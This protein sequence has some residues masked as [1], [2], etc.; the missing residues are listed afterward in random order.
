MLCNGYCDVFYILEVIVTSPPDA[1]ECITESIVIDE[2]GKEFCSNK[3]GVIVIIPEGSIKSGVNAELKF[4]AMLSAPVK[5]AKNTKPVS[6]I[7]WLC[8]NADLQK[9]I[10]IKIPH[11]VS[12][13]SNADANYLQFAKAIHSSSDGSMMEIMDGG[14]FDVGKSHGTIEVNH[15]CYYCILYNYYRNHNLVYKYQAVSFQSKQP[16]RG[17]WK[18]DICIVP[19]LPTCLQVS[20]YISFVFYVTSKYVIE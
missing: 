18:F 17:V 3:H 9:S 10:K 12:I 8:M 7:I 4:G 14:E 5:F 1:H 15:F 2:N 6:P 13:E 16:Y 20:S 11:Y 19:S